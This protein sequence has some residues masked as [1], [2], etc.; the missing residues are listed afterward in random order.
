MAGKDWMSEELGGGHSRQ[1]EQ[2]MQKLRD[3]KVFKNNRN[4]CVEG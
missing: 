1:M 2:Q 4:Y 3:R